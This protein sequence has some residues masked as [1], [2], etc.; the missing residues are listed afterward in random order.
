MIMETNGKTSFFTD[1]PSMQYEKSIRNLVT[2]KTDQLHENLITGWSLPE[3]DESNIEYNNSSIGK[4][5]YR[6]G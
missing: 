6:Y 4:R 2:G 5:G 3:K 1:Q